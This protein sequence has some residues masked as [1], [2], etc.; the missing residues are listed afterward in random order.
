LRLNS[1]RSLAA[2]Q[3]TYLADIDTD[4]LRDGRQR[5]AALS[6]VLDRRTGI[7]VVAAAPELR[8]CLHLLTRLRDATRLPFVHILQAS[9][10]RTNGGR[11]SCV[12]AIPLCS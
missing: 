9:D 7:R 6:H 1:F 2:Q 4:Q 12:G 5:R 3:R 8:L 11:V 10:Q